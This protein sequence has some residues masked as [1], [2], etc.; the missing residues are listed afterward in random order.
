MYISTATKNKNCFE[1][2]T[3]VYSKQYSEVNEVVLV[4]GCVDANHLGRRYAER[5]GVNDASECL[6]ELSKSIKDNKN[7][8][9][10]LLEA[11]IKAEDTHQNVCLKLSDGKVFIL[12]YAG[13]EGYIE[14][15]EVTTFFDES[16]C[17]KK[18]YPKPGDIV[19]RV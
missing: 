19:I 15:F 5:G 2:K 13:F 6:N 4:F 17:G 18:F 7:V 8:V 16:F 12:Q 9:D 14:A 3:S 1:F 10:K 11:H